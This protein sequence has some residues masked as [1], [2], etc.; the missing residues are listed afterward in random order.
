MK[1]LV[2]FS[3]S[4]VKNREGRETLVRSHLKNPST[5]IVVTPA[6]LRAKT[7]HFGV[8]ARLRVLCSLFESR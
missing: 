7:L 5:R 3:A 8:Q 4:T 2:D 6:R 1:R